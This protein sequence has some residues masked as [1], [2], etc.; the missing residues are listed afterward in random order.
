MTVLKRSAHIL[1]YPLAYIINYS[2]E[3]GVFPQYLKTTIVKPILKKGNKKDVKNYRP[4]SLTSTF[5]KIFETIICD[6]IRKHLAYNDVISRS[7]HGF[8][9]GKSTLSAISDFLQKI[10][11]GLDNKQNTFGIFCDLSKAFDS[12][13]HN[14]L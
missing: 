2:F 1:A 4:I 12:V 6:R 10:I 3:Q 7:Q 5:S 14:M 8:V 9:S 13:N 11:N